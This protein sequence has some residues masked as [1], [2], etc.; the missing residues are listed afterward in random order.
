MNKERDN[1]ESVFD[2]IK[3]VWKCTHYHTALEHPNC[4]DKYVAKFGGRAVFFDIESSSLVGNFGLCLAWS[5]KP[6]D[7][8][9]VTHTVMT[10]EE[11]HNPDIMDKRVVGELV[12]ELK[13]YNL[14]ITYYGTG[15]DFPFTR[16]R[17][18]AW[19]FEYPIYGQIRHFDVYYI[20]R[21]KLSLHSKRLDVVA[22]L[23]GIRGK[24]PLNF[25][26]WQRALAG[27]VKSLSYV[28]DHNI[29]DVIILEKVYKKMLPFM[30]GTRKSI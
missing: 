23:L 10:T 6:L 9:L 19:G 8:D 16:T 28:E 4:W 7:V 14:I 27:D 30:A 29:K 15:H 17:A 18:L 5:L 22:D 11:C 3:L 20:A 2:N 24:T 25:R 1:I 13:K 21:S 12:D 26:I